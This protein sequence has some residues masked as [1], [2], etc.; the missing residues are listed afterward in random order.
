MLNEKVSE[1]DLLNTEP[2]CLKGRLSSPNWD[3]SNEI[4]F[5]RRVNL[6]L[7]MVFNLTYY[8]IIFQWN[9]KMMEI[10]SGVIGI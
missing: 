8:E 3:R 9:L 5:K 1:M 6:T 7:N 2:G 4:V 10:Q